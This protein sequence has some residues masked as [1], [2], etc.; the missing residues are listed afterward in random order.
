M[1]D[2]SINCQF[3][4]CD[5]V[6]TSRS[7]NIAIA[8]LSSHSPVHVSAQGGTSTSVS[9]APT[10]D[11][12]SLGLDISEEDWDDFENLWKQFKKV[13]KLKP[14]EE[15]THLF[16]CCSSDLKQQLLKSESGVLEKN[17]ADLRKAMKGLAVIPV[18]ISVRRTELLSMGQ[19]KGEVIKSFFA[20]VRGK[21][22]TCRFKIKC[23]VCVA[24]N[25]TVVDYTEEVV[26]DV[27]IHGIYDADIK[28]EILG[29]PKLEDFTMS[30]LIGH[31]EGK[32]MARDAIAGGVLSNAA[33]S[34]FKKAGKE[35]AKV[36]AEKSDK[37]DP[38][39]KLHASKGKCEDCGKEMALY[40][41]GRKNF[42]NKTAFKSCLACFKKNKE[43]DDKKPN[44]MTEI[45]F[46]FCE[47]KLNSQ[48]IRRNKAQKRQLKKVGDQ[49][50]T[51]AA[52]DSP[53]HPGRRSVVLEHHIFEDGSWIRKD[54]TSHPKLRLALDTVKEDYDALG[55]P[56]PKVKVTYLDTVS[57]TGAQLCLWSR[58]ECMNSG[59][60]KEDLIPVKR[61]VQA[62]NRTQ[63]T[64]DGAV[65]V[66]L[67]GKDGDGNV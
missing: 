2:I 30:A 56:Y 18:A 14:D 45:A 61:T 50:F 35:G 37:P 55:M 63:I 38:D 39:E 16:Q 10:V 47:V 6:A 59:F 67:S 26:K 49:T 11:R 20:K 3:P 41:K 65:I 53:K 44:E 32:E 29:L 42:W 33:L 64:V 54:F 9:K 28:Q 12:P 52:T 51:V 25:V 19:D 58:K 1:A 21:A 36:K 60:H 17:E 7:E 46:S 40:S 62:A 24:P 43:S 34:S 48:K 8:M 5:Y 57:D 23:P 22:L 31:I 13:T 4:N 66:R 15:A 27:L